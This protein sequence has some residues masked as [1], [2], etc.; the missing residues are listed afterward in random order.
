MAK[1]GERIKGKVEY[2]L[3]NGEHCEVKDIRLYIQ[4]P[5]F[6]SFLNSLY[7]LPHDSLQYFLRLR[8]VVQVKS[9]E[10]TYQPKR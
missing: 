1:K 7:F 3:E 2:I 8:L 6:F 9:L 4:I 10:L 5:Y